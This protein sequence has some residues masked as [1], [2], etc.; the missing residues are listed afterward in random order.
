MGYGENTALVAYGRH[1]ANL[2][3]TSHVNAAIITSAVQV[4]DISFFDDPADKTDWYS[5][6][7]ANGV[8]FSPIDNKN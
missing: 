8:K 5:L 7:T 1:L 6:Y 4:D 3:D 2:S